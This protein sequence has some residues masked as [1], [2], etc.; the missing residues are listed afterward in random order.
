MVAHAALVQLRALGCS[1][2]V[3]LGAATI[4]SL[5][6]RRRLRRLGARSCSGRCVS[7]RRAGARAAGRASI[8]PRALVARRADADAVI[9][10]ARRA[11]DCLRA[12][13]DAASW[14]DCASLR[15]VFTGGEALVAATA[16][17][18][19][20]RQPTA[21]A[22]GNV[23]RPDRDRPSTRRS[24][25]RATD[26]ASTA[27]VPIGRPIANTQRLRARRARASRCRSASPGELYIG[28]DGAGA[29]LP[30]P[31]RADRRALRARPVRRRR[32]RGCTAPATW[33]A[34]CPTA[35]SSSS[36]A[37]PPGQDP[38]LPHRARR[39]RGGAR[40]AP[41]GAP[42]RRCCCAR[43]RRRRPRW[44]PTSSANER[45]RSTSRELRARAARRAARVHGA[46]GLRRRSTRC[47]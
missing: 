41:G 20:R 29:R 6:S 40:A 24:A 26:D 45:R 5:Q 44:S 17:A 14:R 38:R 39:D 25:R 47:R 37:R 31:A 13:V 36:A 23:L 30:R 7:G 10:A 43:T 42:G 19:L 33:R 2:Y 27:V 3:R 8:G 22:A 11:V 28:G 16:R 21:R 4:A 35:R 46:G 32:A 34:G 15:R 9:R 12:I 18:A 1:T